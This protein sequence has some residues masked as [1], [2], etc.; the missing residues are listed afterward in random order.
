MLLNWIEL[1][2]FYSNKS[3]ITQWERTPFGMRY[4]N[5]NL[6]KLTQK[7]KNAKR[8]PPPR[9]FSSKKIN[10]KLFIFKVIQEISIV[11]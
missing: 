5:A 8:G 1:I 11:K 10:K 2:F 4:L 3:I 7:D 9:F 6:L